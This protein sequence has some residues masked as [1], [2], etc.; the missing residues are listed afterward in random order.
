MIKITFLSPPL[1]LNFCSIS[2]LSIRAAHFLVPDVKCLLSF[3]EL[4][5]LPHLTDIIIL[6]TVFNEV[7]SSKLLKEREQQKLKHR[8]GGSRQLTA[9]GK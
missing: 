1:Q 4:F 2:L 9:N 7:C 3:L 5:E 8:S 6:Q